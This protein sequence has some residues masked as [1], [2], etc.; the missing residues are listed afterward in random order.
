LAGSWKYISNLSP[1]A[2]CWYNLS[3]IVNSL[4]YFDQ[5][6]ALSTRSLLLVILGIVILLGGV[7][8]VSMPASNHEGGIEI[9]TWHEDAEEQGEIRLDM[10]SDAL[11][12]S[13][14]NGAD[15]PSP[16]HGLGLGRVW[17][18]EP[19]STE[20]V[21][22]LPS[23]PTPIMD[24][25]SPL[26]SPTSSRRRKPSGSGP[27]P[28]R[29]GSTHPLSPPLSTASLGGFAIGISAA[30]PGF[31]VLPRSRGERRVASGASTFADVVARTQRDMRRTAS[32]GDVGPDLPTSPLARS[33][34]PPETH[35][36]S[37]SAH[38]GHAPNARGR[39]QWLRGVFHR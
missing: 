5:F 1:V 21:A 19:S 10:E 7:G 24:I 14:A 34:F 8:V 17:S 27:D 32:E 31:S 30:S 25:T 35:A 26:G 33:A 36:A 38:D 2:F 20:G 11:H 3:S 9:N 13:P 15:G 29:R 23:G 16:H 28:S 4:V 39:W 12:G 6:S 37:S 22:G 18:H